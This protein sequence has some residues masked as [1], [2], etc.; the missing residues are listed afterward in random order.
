MY[1]EIHQEIPWDYG[2][3]KE[4]RAGQQHKN[5]VSLHCCKYLLTNSWSQARQ[6]HCFAVRFLDGMIYCKEIPLVQ[7]AH[8]HI[9]FTSLLSTGG[10]SPPLDNYKFGTAAPMNVKDRKSSTAP[11]PSFFKTEFRWDFQ[12]WCQG[13]ECLVTPEMFNCPSPSLKGRAWTTLKLIIQLTVL[14]LKMAHLCLN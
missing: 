5:I 13:S 14:V 9:L 2:V 7:R 12:G 3:K 10:T 8:H 1:P 6:K 4:E 11:P